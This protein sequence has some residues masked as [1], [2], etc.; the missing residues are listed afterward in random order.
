M[1]EPVLILIGLLIIFVLFVLPQNKK[2]AFNT[3]PQSNSKN[4]STYSAFNEDIGPGTSLYNQNINLDS[5]NASYESTPVDEYLT[6]NNSGRTSVAISGW[7]ITDIPNTNSYRQT[8]T[9][10]SFSSSKAILP[11]GTT[12]LS[13]TGKN[14]LSPII[15]KP[16]DNAIVISGWVGARSLIPIVSFKENKCT[17]YLEADAD[18]EFTPRLERSCDSPSD[19]PGFENLDTKCQDF[20]ENMGTCHTPSFQ[21]K[22]SYGE[23]CTN[24]VDGQNDFSSS[25]R[26]YLKSHFTYSGCLANHGNDSDFEGKTW[27]IFLGSKF[28]LWPDKQATIN[29]FDGSGKLVDY[30]S[31]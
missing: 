19:E 3:L 8:K 12:F 20:I 24:C 18:Y 14:S 27:R 7:Q 9:P 23:K 26:A 15:L 1:L 4:P 28:E 30:A 5:G 10:A 13:A 2:G 21:S 25:C 6:I 31:Y 17:G 16:G 11:I 29:L 22:N